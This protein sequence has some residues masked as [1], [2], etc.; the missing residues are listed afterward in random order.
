MSKSHIDA[1]VLDVVL[2]VN[3]YRKSSVMTY[4]S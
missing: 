3:I 1:N 2:H 4:V